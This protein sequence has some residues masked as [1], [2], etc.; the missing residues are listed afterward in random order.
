[1]APPHQISSPGLPSAR[2]VCT[3]LFRKRT[4]G[5]PTLQIRTYATLLNTGCRKSEN[6]ILG[7]SVSRTLGESS[8]TIFVRTFLK[9]CAAV[10]VSKYAH[11]LPPA[12]ILTSIKDTEGSASFILESRNTAPYYRIHTGNLVSIQLNKKR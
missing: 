9:L 12:R 5:A 7:V 3:L 11:L 6:R 2:N 10:L 8:M 1:M 4:A